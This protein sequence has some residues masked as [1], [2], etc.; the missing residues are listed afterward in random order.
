[1]YNNWQKTQSPLLTSERYFGQFLRLA[2]LE[3]FL[4]LRGALQED[5]E[6]DEAIEFLDQA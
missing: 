5:E 2:S 1:L 3:Q 6:F 4:A